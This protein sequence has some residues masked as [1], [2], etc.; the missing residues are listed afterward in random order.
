MTEEP[1]KESP[2]ELK[3]KERLQRHIDMLK[4]SSEK[5]GQLNPVVISQFGVV[6]GSKRLSADPNWRMKKVQLQDEYE[7][8]KVVA[9][10]NIQMEP[11][12]EEWRLYLS[13]AID[14][15]LEKNKNLKREDI[16]KRLTEDFGLQKTKLYELIPEEYKKDYDTSKGADL[17]KPKNDESKIPQSGIT[18]TKRPTAFDMEKLLISELQ[19]ADI[20]PK[21]KVPYERPYNYPQPFFA[22][23][24]V[25]NLAMD[26][27]GKSTKEEIVKRDEFFI[28]KHGLYPIHFPVPMVKKYAPIIA[29]LIH[30]MV[31]K[32]S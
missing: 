19:K 9:N 18:E 22:D 11:S 16:V 6:S 17:Y 32:T 1:K 15:L 13:K 10:S 23:I 5:V 25:G 3:R 8:W 28:K 26:I 29:S 20:N 12:Q 24:V 30:G 21:V 4:E 27:V 31:G 14:A 7:H 2:R